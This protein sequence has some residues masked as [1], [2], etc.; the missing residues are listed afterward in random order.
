MKK[1]I[2]NSLTVAFSLAILVSCKK[3]EISI[4]KNE[5]TTWEIDK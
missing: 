2:F 3:D 5:S 1:I 4:E